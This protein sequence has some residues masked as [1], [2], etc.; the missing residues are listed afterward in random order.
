MGDTMP[1]AE[2]HLGYSADILQGN[3][4]ASLSSQL[5]KSTIWYFWW[6]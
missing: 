2:E 5:K 4:L 3:N 6:D 1:I